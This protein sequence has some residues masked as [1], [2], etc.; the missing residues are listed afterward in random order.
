MWKC[1]SVLV[2]KWCQEWL[3]IPMVKLFNKL[4][5]PIKKWCKFRLSNL[6]WNLTL[7][8]TRMSSCLWRT[9]FD[10]DMVSKIQYGLYIDW[11]IESGYTSKVLTKCRTCIPKALK[12]YSYLIQWN[13]FILHIMMDTCKM[14]LNPPVKQL[15]CEYFV[16]VNDHWTLKIITSS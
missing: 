13:Y 9:P 7:Y 2:T 6:L 4:L 11:L 10:P 15:I 14:L 3:L 5:V 1:F 16:Y 12:G 8:T